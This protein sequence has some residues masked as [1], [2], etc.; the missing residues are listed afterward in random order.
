MISRISDYLLPEYLR[1]CNSASPRSEIRL[2]ERRQSL[3]PASH[4][5]VLLFAGVPRQCGA[6]LLTIRPGLL[7]A[8]FRIGLFIK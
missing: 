1:H 4:V 2:I 5:G 7:L 6:V 8:S 3:K